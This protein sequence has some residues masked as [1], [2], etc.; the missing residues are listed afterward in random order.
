M[1]AGSRRVGDEVKPGHAPHFHGTSGLAR[2]FLSL[3]PLGPRR[4]RK[5]PEPRPRAACSTA[6][7]G[8][9]ASPRGARPASPR[10][11][12]RPKTRKNEHGLDAVCRS[13][14]GGG[15]AGERASRP[16]VLAF[17]PPL[18]A[19]LIAA[20]PPS[21]PHLDPSLKGL[22]PSAGLPAPLRSE[23]A[24]CFLSSPLGQN[25]R[26]PT[27]PSPTGDSPAARASRRLGPVVFA[28][29]FFHLRRGRGDLQGAES[30]GGARRIEEKTAAA[31]S[32]LQ[33]EDEA[34]AAFHVRLLLLLLLAAAAVQVA[35][36][37]V[38]S[39]SRPRRLLLPH[40]G[41]VLDRHPCTNL[42]RPHPRELASLTG[43]SAPLP[44]PPRLS[45]R[46]FW[47]KLGR[48]LFGESELWRRLFG[49]GTVRDVR[50]GG[51]FEPCPPA[52]FRPRYFCV[53]GA[54]V[55]TCEACARARCA[56]FLP[57]SRSEPLCTEESEPHLRR[58][59]ESPGWGVNAAR[60]FQRRRRRRA[61]Q[62]AA[63]V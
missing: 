46:I 37:Q 36:Q 2:V 26:S 5:P 3:L 17:F 20:S 33:P 48:G 52:S 57:L 1:H 50:S 30:R 47:R 22:T 4:P 28:C 60:G 6:H 15:G 32:A 18:G 34:F 43:P 35:A 11:A 61:R 24:T 40:H 29:P 27:P 39:S 9:P 53:A 54:A 56:F 44:S 51:C 10:L 23:P 41:S 63:S 45:H 19:T 16:R 8:E 62:W 42:A 55:A 58:S 21:P 13:R 38:R 14:L 59:N 12:L 31:C 7:A 25:T 49:R